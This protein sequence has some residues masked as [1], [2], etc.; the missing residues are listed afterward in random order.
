MEKEKRLN[1][2]LTFF[3][4][5][6][7]LFFFAHGFSDVMGMIATCRL[8]LR[9][10]YKDVGDDQFAFE[11]TS[12]DSERDEDESHGILQVRRCFLFFF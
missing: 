5:F 10:T 3:F 9:E 8:W 2:I 11:L 1:T 12:Y 7:F 4:L 6:L